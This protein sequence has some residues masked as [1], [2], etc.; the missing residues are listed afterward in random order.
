MPSGS[1]VI[2]P[3]MGI[4]E[5]P[6]LE[7]E[8]A[9]TVE[10]R[11]LARNAVVTFA[12]PPSKDRLLAPLT[13]AI[14]RLNKQFGEICLTLRSNLVGLLSTVSVP[15]T[16]ANASAHDMHWQRIRSAAGIRALMLDAKP[17]ETNEE[18]DLRRAGE[19]QDRARAEM[20]RYIHSSEGEEALIRT[21]LNFLERLSSDRS[22]LEAAN[23]LI[24]QGVVLCWA[25]FEVFARDCF[26]AYL[27]ANPSR[28]LALLEEP[29]AKRR[30]LEAAKISLET[31]AEYGFNLSERMGSLLAKHQDLSD[32]YSVKSAYQ[33]LFPERGKLA[34]ALSDTNL[35][36]LS[37]RRNLI[38]HQRGVI[39]EA[40]AASTKCIQRAGE[41]LKV[42]PSDLETHLNTTV[43][44]AASILDSVSTGM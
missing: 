26:I 14:A 40:Y 4:E 32:V 19:A 37:L 27:N 1:T 39:D 2:Q 18:L 35:R 13:D 33:G 36:L 22:F 5:K 20:D 11:T 31:L 12:I 17:G 9:A 34:D 29:V 8:S 24:L 10:L 25:A 21:T 30:F 44:V 42:S 38:V 6:S 15:Y 7:T 28:T 41:R 23:E 16:M 3:T 43:K